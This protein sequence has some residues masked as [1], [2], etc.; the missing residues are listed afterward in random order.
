MRV[1]YHHHDGATPNGVGAQERRC[2]VGGS[3]ARRAA[4][5][6]CGDDLQT[7]PSQKS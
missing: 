1:R 5:P 6:G 2:K 7:A 3:D 4:L